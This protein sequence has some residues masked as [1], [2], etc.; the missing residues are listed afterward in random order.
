MRTL[1]TSF[2]LVFFLTACAAP[3]AVPPTA[4]LTPMP[5]TATLE[6]SPTATQLA[7]TEVVPTEIVVEGL[8]IAPEDLCLWK[9]SPEMQCFAPNMET[10]PQLAENLK[11]MSTTVAWLGTWNAKDKKPG[12]YATLA[13]YEQMINSNPQQ[14][15]M[16]VDMMWHPD[17]RNLSATGAMWQKASEWIGPDGERIGNDALID[18]SSEGLELVDWDVAKKEGGYTRMMAGAQV[19]QTLEPVVGQDGVWRVVWRVTNELT[20]MDKTRA[21]VLGVLIPDQSLPIEK[22]KTAW[23]QL[24]NWLQHIM[25]LANDDPKS[26]LARSGS[27]SSYLEFAKKGVDV[28]LEVM[29]EMQNEP[30]FFV[31]GE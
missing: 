20:L 15:A 1:I 31:A 25:K 10:I 21:D 13:A 3:I 9:D 30:Q 4:T 2:L 5:P 27:G 28:T 22:N 18:F 14:L 12:D 26:S 7:S 16:K 8:Q 11:R 17:N 24:M 23:N 6:P 29:I 19:K